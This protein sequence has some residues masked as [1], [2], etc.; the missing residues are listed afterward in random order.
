MMAM[1]LIRVLLEGGPTDLTGTDRV[2]EVED[3]SE[4][5]KVPRGSG[6]EHFRYSGESRDLQGSA[7]PVYQWCDRTKIAE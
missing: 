5:V 2:H 1:E 4:P 7:V 6:R 3:L